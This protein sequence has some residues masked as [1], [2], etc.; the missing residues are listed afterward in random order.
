MGPETGHS[1]QMGSPADPARAAASG[2]LPSV[3]RQMLQGKGGLQLDKESLPFCRWCNQLNP[4]VKKE[5]FGEWEDAVI[6]KVRESL[7]L[8]DG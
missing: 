8:K 7:Q 6:I 5:A 2:V 4:D 3:F 1:S